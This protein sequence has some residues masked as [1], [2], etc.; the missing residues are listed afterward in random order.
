[1]VPKEGIALGSDYNGGVKHLHPGCPVGTALDGAGLW[2]IGQSGVVWQSLEKLGAPVP[3]PRRRV[4]E[5]FLSAWERVTS[6]PDP[7]KR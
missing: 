3:R 7:A 6:H 2:N 5:Y 1:V 4:I